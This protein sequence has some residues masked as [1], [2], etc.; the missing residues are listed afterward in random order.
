[1]KDT[2]NAPPKNGN[3]SNDTTI[4]IKREQ[5]I[6]LVQEYQKHGF[7][8]LLSYTTYIFGNREKIMQTETYI[9]PVSAPV[10]PASPPMTKQNFPQEQPA[11]PNPYKEAYERETETTQ[12]LQAAIEEMLEFTVETHER[13]GLFNFT[14]WSREAIESRFA[15][16]LRQ[17]GLSH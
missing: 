17:N 3:S 9:P 14:S 11:P 16:I 12:R 5:H 15:Q 13:K 4:R 7:E 6:E 2:P 1:M 10:L 8:N